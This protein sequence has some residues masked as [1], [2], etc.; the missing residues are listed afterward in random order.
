MLFRSL[1]GNAGGRFYAWVIGGS[2]DASLAA[3]WLAAAWDQ[4]AG[5]YAVSPA[6]AIVEEIAG[7]WLKELLALPASVS[8]ALVT[9]GQ[10]ANTTGIAAGRYRV[11]ANKGWDVEKQGLF[12]APRIRVVT[13]KHRHATIARSVRLLGMGK[14]G[15]AHV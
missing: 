15:R 6:S 2:V 13:G 11:L 10:M 5:M 8:F 4:N 1:L 3:D 7:A 12:G 14:I 9:G